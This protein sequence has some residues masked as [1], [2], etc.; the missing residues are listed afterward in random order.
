[1]Y[2]LEIFE[3]FNIYM[4]FAKK[5]PENAKPPAPRRPPPPRPKPVTVVRG[6]KYVAPEDVARK[7]LQIRRFCQSES[8][9]LDC[10]VRWAEV[11]ELTALFATA[12][13]DPDLCEPDAFLAWHR[14]RYK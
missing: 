5:P 3:S 1:M 8:C 6:Y 14:S 2:N 13:Q 11:R 7:I 4:F 10:V 9:Y 12:L